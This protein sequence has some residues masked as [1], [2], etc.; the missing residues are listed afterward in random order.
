MQ[1]RLSWPPRGGRRTNCELASPVTSCGEALRIALRAD[2]GLT[3][4]AILARRW[5]WA[6][7][8]REIFGEQLL[9]AEEK[10]GLEHLKGGAWHPFRRKWA[11][12]QKGLPLVAARAM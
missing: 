8:S 7:A 2:R 1:P 3:W 10:A 5:F 11:T 6:L 12:E 9:V 4:L